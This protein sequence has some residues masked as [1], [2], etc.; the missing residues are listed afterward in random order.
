MR[1]A[2]SS[3]RPCGRN[4]RFRL[5]SECASDPR[6]CRGSS[7]PVM[8]AASGCAPPMPPMP[9]ETISLPSRLPPKCLRASFGEG[10]VGALHDSLA[11]DVDP[12]AGGHLA[13]HHQAL[14]FELVEIPPSWTSGPPGWRWRSAPAAPGCGCAK[15]PPACPIGSAASHRFRAISSARTMA[16]KQGQSRAAFPVPP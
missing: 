15:C 11:A 8:V 16:W 4:S 13:V 5:A 9:P 2:S 1:R 14:S 7:A 12:G 10:F 3:V 6:R